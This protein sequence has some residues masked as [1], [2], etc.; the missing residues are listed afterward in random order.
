MSNILDQAIKFLR[1]SHSPSEVQAV[2]RQKLEA[3]TQARSSA[4]VRLPSTTNTSTF[5]NSP[6]KTM[7]VGSTQPRPPQYICLSS[8]YQIEQDYGPSL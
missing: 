8:L 7:R 3:I 1:H 5:K 6:L 2:L 4:T